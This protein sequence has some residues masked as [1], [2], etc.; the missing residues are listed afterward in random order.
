MTEENSGDISEKTVIDIA[1]ERMRQEL[2]GVKTGCHKG[3]QSG[4]Q[5]PRAE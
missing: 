5:L 2:E 4:S 3:T 1:V